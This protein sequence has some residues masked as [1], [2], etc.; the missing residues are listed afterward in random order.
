MDNCF[1]SEGFNEKDMPALTNNNCKWCPYHKT[2]L[3]SATFEG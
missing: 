1:T 2:H 3:C